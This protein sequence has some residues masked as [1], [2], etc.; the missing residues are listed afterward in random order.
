M[1]VFGDPM[2]FIALLSTHDRWHTRAV[3][4]SRQPPGP[5]VTTEWVLTEVGGAF[6]LPGVWK[7]FSRLLE[8][9]RAQA[10]VEIIP[11]TSDPFRRGAELFAV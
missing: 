9:L 10:D 6:S 7:K 4:M 2:H 11:S 8:L 3:A 1:R 5:L